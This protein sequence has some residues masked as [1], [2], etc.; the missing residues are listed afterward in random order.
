[1]RGGVEIRQ[2]LIDDDSWCKRGPGKQAIGRFRGGIATK[3]H[4][5]VDVLGGPLGIVLSPGNTHENVI[6][7]EM[8]RNLELSDK[9]VIADRW[10]SLCYI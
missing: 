3:I 7:Y 4:T 5:V 10:N 9:Q 6:R 1:M 8:L 2:T